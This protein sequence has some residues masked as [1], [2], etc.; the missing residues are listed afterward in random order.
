[1]FDG[2]FEVVGHASGQAHRV[3][4]RFQHPAMLRSQQVEGPLGIPI[5]RR[6]AHQPEQFQAF[7]LRDLRADLIDRALFR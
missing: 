3:R 4:V 1:M 6:D 5:Q 2:D 7:G